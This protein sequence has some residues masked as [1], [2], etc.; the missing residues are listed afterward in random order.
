MQQ[1]TW[2]ITGANSG[3]G[4]HMT[5]QLLARGDRVAATVRQL[6]AMD[7]LKAL[8]GDRLWLA[9][10]DLTD[11]PAIRPLVD[12]A[13][14]ELGKI[15][16]VVS[17]AGYG[18]FGVAEEATDAQML[19]QLG[20]NL[21]GSMQLVR[22]ALPH[23]RQLG[24]GR[25]LQLSTMG[26]QAAF[27]AGSMY[28][29]GKWGIEGFIDSVAQEV[30]VFN[31]GCTLVEPGSA[32]TGFRYRGARW[33]PKIDAYDASPAGMA[34]RMIEAGNSVQI[35]DPAKMAAIIIASVEQH[36]APKRIALGSD[37]YNIMHKQLSERLAALEAQ[38]EL[39]FSTDF[40]LDA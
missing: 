34:R 24:G 26:G 14:S 5:E 7:D 21:T 10:L 32:R 17:N 15:D 9:S 3:F 25:I 11:L 40:P 29:A 23:L 1:R 4:R 20:T 22:S 2:L 13:F 16:V 19:H 28:H 33:T 18:L 8:Y 12:R 39:A 38:K 27:P 6:A 36:P 31:I 35:G 37:A 30:A